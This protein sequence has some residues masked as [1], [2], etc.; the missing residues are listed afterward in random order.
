MNSR[1][2]HWKVLLPLRRTAAGWLTTG[3]C[4]SLLAGCQAVPPKVHSLAWTAT[5]S[6]G[7]ALIPQET[8]AWCWA[9]TAQMIMAA[10][11]VNLKQCQIANQQLGA[12]NCPC[13]QCTNFAQAQPPCLKTGWPE[14]D[15]FGFSCKRTQFGR[16]L[17][18]SELVAALGMGPIAFSWQEGGNGI[19]IMVATDAVPDPNGP[20][21]S[22]DILDPS[23]GCCCGKA[24]SIT[25]DQYVSGTDGYVGH[26]IDFYAIQH[27]GQTATASPPFPCVDDQIA[28]PP[29][30][31]TGKPL[32]L[33]SLSTEGSSAVAPS[34]AALLANQSW[35]VTDSNAI[36]LGFARSEQFATAV[37]A[38][39]IA[40]YSIW[41]NELQRYK[42]GDDVQ[43]LLH[44]SDAQ[45][46]PLTVGG[47]VR[48][49]IT[50][51]HQDSGFVLEQI[52]AANLVGTLSRHL[53][54][55]KS[56]KHLAPGSYFKL[57]IL[58]FNLD[59][60]GYRDATGIFLQALQD[61]PW[62]QLKDGQ[63]VPL[64]QVV[65]ALAPFALQHD[66][67]PA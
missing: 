49:S 36:R 42:A 45:I 8:W 10:S 4:L 1:K 16:A 9:A 30:N 34:V 56:T 38:A 32:N 39:P 20:T 19:H 60:L 6:N 28:P 25:Y 29:P 40:Q 14:F 26:A 27:T 7:V 35:M 41:L 59:F 3:L 47:Q 44:A 55:L 54:E 17:T 53:D 67:G 64:Q 24:T 12:T 58:A 62:L 66:G 37:P 50:L 2:A 61:Q 63:I 31:S 48:S 18:W 15:R 52:G 22:V 65:D 57:S 11:N 33:E 13:G 23:P 5:V 43:S 21:G 46:V 51:R